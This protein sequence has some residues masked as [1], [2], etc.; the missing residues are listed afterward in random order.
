MNTENEW[1]VLLTVT[2][3]TDEIKARIEVDRNIFRFKML[4][5]IALKTGHQWATNPPVG[6]RITPFTKTSYALTWAINRALLEASHLTCTWAPNGNRWVLGVE[7]KPMYVVS[8]G[9]DGKT[10]ESL[11]LVE[12]V[13]VAHPAALALSLQLRQGRVLPDDDILSITTRVASRVMPVLVAA[14]NWGIVGENTLS[15]LAKLPW[16]IAVGA[17]SDEA[18]TRRHEKSSIGV[19]GS[20]PNSGVTVVAYG[21]NPFVPGTFGTSFAVPRALAQVLT[22]TSFVLQISQIDETHRTGRLGGVPLLQRLSV[23]T[24]FASFDPRPSLPLP[25]IPLVGVDQSAVR[26][27]AQILRAAGARMA[28]DPTPEIIRRMLVDS[29]RPMPE[30]DSSEV[31]AGFVSTETTLEYLRNFNAL[32][33]AKLFVVELSLDDAICATLS[34][35]CLADTARLDALQELTCR[36]SL[37]YSIDF[38]TGSIFASM[39]DPEREE[40]AHGFRKEQSKYSWPP[41]V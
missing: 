39:R 2:K 23:D 24:G 7:G 3:V 30:Y 38:H 5:F 6:T 16:T 1:E 8:T 15:P 21:E 34:Q 28:I 11:A 25:M 26:L 14:G 9:E 22:L 31:G 35:L 12:E 18:G 32:D 17:T 37:I 36:S 20:D 19:R 40:G 29:A 27:A 13:R 4:P 10:I 41:P 33:L